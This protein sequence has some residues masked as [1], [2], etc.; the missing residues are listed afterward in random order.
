MIK[1][2][3]LEV[4]VLSMAMKLHENVGWPRMLEAKEVCN[5]IQDE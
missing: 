5:S 2:E 3:V 1:Q 4:E